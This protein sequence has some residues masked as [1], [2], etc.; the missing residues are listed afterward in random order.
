VKILLLH[1]GGLGDCLLSLPAIR[2]LRERFPAAELTVAGNLD[3]LGAIL[4]GYAERVISLSSLPLHHLYSAA[5]LPREEVHFWRS[6]DRIVSWTGSGNPEFV[7]KLKEIH[8]HACIAP[9]KPERGETRHVSQLFADSIE[10]VIHLGRPVEPAAVFLNQA[11]RKE[12]MLWL[13]QRG[14]ENMDSLTALHPGAGSKAK[15]W[16][17]KQF[18]HIA[19]HFVFKEKRKLLVIEGP[20]ETGLAKQITG[21]LPA[22]SSIPAESL[23]LGLLAA[24][25]EQCRLFIG[26]D[27]GIAHLAAA[28]QVPSVVLFGPT[29]P[30]HWA[31]LGRHVRV[32]RNP[33]GC[34]GCAHGAAVH[35]CLEN[36]TVQ[37][38]IRSSVVPQIRASRSPSP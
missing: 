5:P 28:L 14:C 34:E 10:P 26:N 20:A 3:H 25:V 17:L 4:S 2:L 6:F 36:I 31:P 33:Q 30:R 37:D 16:P 35:T 18:A 32:L 38:V 13:A 12:G 1:P 9:W 11:L 27:S 22:N 8:P 23:P 21:G 24:V 7:R 29:L 15:R 19:R